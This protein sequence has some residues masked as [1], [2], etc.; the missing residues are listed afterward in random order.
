M[1]TGLETALTGAATQ[2]V[3]Q[4][5]NTQDANKT[6]DQLLDMILGAESAKVPKQS[7]AALYALIKS[8]AQIG[9][10]IYSLPSQDVKNR[11]TKLLESTGLLVNN[12]LDIEKL[13]DVKKIETLTQNIQLF[14]QADYQVQ[15]K[16][17]ESEIGLDTSA[18]RG[19]ASSTSFFGW[20]GNV[21]LKIGSAV[22]VEP[23]SLSFAQRWVNEAA[24]YT[25]KPIKSGKIVEGNP[26][27]SKIDA[28]STE[29]FDQMVQQVSGIYLSGQATVQDM[30]V[31][32]AAATQHSYKP[33]LGAGTP[34]SLREKEPAAPAKGSGASD[35]KLN[36]DLLS[37][38]K[39]ELTEPPKGFFEKAKSWL[40]GS[41]KADVEGAGRNAH[42]SPI[43]APKV[44]GPK[45]D[46]S[47]M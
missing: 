26:N 33:A 42:A 24:D 18:R 14:L 29:R 5:I 12:K 3:G 17:A 34:N 43:N 10:D 7:R 21:I 47:G 44:S 38:T 30:G 4:A 13:K 11:A 8:A 46:L 32:A 2:A 9:S 1:A 28:I 23:D 15:G 45:L 35:P 22:G 25:G 16:R 27:L 6:D 41:N 39:R 36:L 19:L 31:R 40:F 20:L 37:S